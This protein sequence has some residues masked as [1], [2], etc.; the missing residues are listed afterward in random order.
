[1]EICRAR[2]FLVKKRW[3]DFNWVCE[4]VLCHLV[5]GHPWCAFCDLSSPNRP[6]LMDASSQK[7]KIQDDSWTEAL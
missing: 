2:T 3:F 6:S 1:M 4:T 5:T 7:N